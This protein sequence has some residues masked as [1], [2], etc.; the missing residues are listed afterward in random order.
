[1]LN[2]AKSSN[3]KVQH[4]D[5]NSTFKTA[6]LCSIMGAGGKSLNKLFVA[7]NSNEFGTSYRQT[8]SLVRRAEQSNV[9]LK[10][11]DWGTTKMMWNLSSNEERRSDSSM[12]TQP[13]AVQN[14][15]QLTHLAAVTALPSGP[16]RPRA[17][18]FPLE[19]LC[20][21]SAGL[22]TLVQ[23]LL[24]FIIQLSWPPRTTEIWIFSDHWHIT[25]NAFNGDLSF[26]IIVG[27]MSLIQSTE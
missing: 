14:L 22:I 4:K 18:A 27:S 10:F 23:V 9:I 8:S 19:G 21:I 15:F 5:S 3:R 24:T 6:L 17:A 1:M 25:C 20:W 2:G 26:T 11:S 13:S 16:E 7:M 12:P